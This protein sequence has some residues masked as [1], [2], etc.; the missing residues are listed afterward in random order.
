MDDSP[1][2]RGVDSLMSATVSI[3]AQLYWSLPGPRE[4][5]HKIAS[6]A[7]TSRVLAINTPRR[8]IAGT[9][10]KVKEGLKNAHVDP[11]IELIIRKGTDISEDVGVHLSTGRITAGQ[12]AAVSENMSTAIMLRA[13][14]PEAN[15]LCAQYTAEF[16]EATEHSHGNIHLV[17][18]LHDIDYQTDQS[19]PDVEIIAFDGGVSQEEMDAYV[20][21]RMITRPGPGSTRLVRAL[22]SEFAGFDVQLAE[23]LMLLDESQ[24]LAIQGTLNGLLDEDHGRWRNESW[25]DGTR[26]SAHPDRHILLDQYLSLNG[27]VAAREEAS[28]RISRRYWKACVKIITPWI[29]ERKALVM[30]YFRPQIDRIAAGNKGKITIPRSNRTADIDPDELELNNIVGMYYSGQITATSPD[31]QS[32]LK[33]CQRV[34]AVRDDIAHLR[35][36]TSQALVDLIYEMDRLVRT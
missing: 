28:T 12:L 23:R 26:S 9:W 6:R 8:T 31:E 14:D 20:S 10:S 16:L 21:L 27:S 2:L 4:F 11:V 5:M 13:E 29:E 17:T 36:P 32:A 15:E 30:K 22:V 24:I 35:A 19:A 1:Y 18:A 7:S 3:D 34:K 33:V 25:L